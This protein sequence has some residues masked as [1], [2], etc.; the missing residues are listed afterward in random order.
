MILTIFL[1]KGLSF[2]L[3]ASVIVLCNGLETKQALTQTAPASV[4]LLQ[5]QAL[6]IELSYKKQ[7][8][9]TLLTAPWFSKD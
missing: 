5:V 1:L 2:E 8:S 6:Y 4:Q 3:N 7:R 9:S